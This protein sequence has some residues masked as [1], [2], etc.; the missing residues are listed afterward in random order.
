MAIKLLFSLPIQIDCA[1]ER[2]R[3]GQL[4]EQDCVDIEER[5]DA[6]GALKSLS[7]SALTVCLSAYTRTVDSGL[8]VSRRSTSDIVSVAG[9]IRHG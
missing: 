9:D 4:E 1:K 8:V 3:S 6:T 7:S 5:S 2:G